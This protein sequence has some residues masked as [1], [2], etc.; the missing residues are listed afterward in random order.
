MNSI[1]GSVGGS[2][3][4]TGNPCLFGCHSSYNPNN[5]APVG[6]KHD[7]EKPAMALLPLHGA[8]AVAK[9]MTYGAKK[10]EAHNYL[11]GIAYLRLASAALRHLFA[12]L[13]GE[14][15]DGESGLPHLAHAAASIMMLIDMTVEHPNLDDRFKSGSK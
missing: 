8:E 10:Y 14:D 6:I 5:P 7:Q 4:C 9:V 3:E 1:C 15:T 12:W 13:R 2:V 11:S